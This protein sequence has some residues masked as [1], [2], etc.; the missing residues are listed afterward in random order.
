M[1]TSEQS[2]RPMAL[3][4][5]DRRRDVQL[6]TLNSFREMAD[7]FREV[8]GTAYEAGMVPNGIKNVAG[9]LTAIWRGAEVGLFPQQAL[10][11]IYIVN[12]LPQLYGDAPKGIVEASGLMEDCQEF[13]EG[14]FPED[15]F[16]AVCLVKRRDHSKPRRSEFSIADAKTA[17][18]WGKTSKDGVPSAWVLY[19]KRM[20]MWRARGYALR[21]EFSDILKGFPIRELMDDEDALFAQARPAVGQVV[22]PII[23]RAEEP[24]KRPRGR[25]PKVTPPREYSQSPTEEQRQQVQAEISE[26]ETDHEP[27]H[28]VKGETKEPAKS[29]F[30]FPPKADP[31]PQEQPKEADKPKR[32]PSPLEEVAAKLA[33]AKASSK[34]FLYLLSFAGLIEADEAG[35]ETGAIG[36]DSIPEAAI[37]DA[38]TD[39]DNAL[40]ALKQKPW[41]A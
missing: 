41:A 18:L 28:G 14:T 25:P 6:H 1:E 9:A 30:E 16:K 12:G 15:G 40:A 27:T 5:I 38:L 21:D 29:L 10:Q 7:F 26:K 19:P 22:E 24:A 4:Q 2:D 20:L 35:I 11:S 13:E 36:L 23:P 32:A 31:E 33:E 34:D 17:K 39:W 8:A 37:K 3:A